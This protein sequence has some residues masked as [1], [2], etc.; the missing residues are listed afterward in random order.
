VPKALQEATASFSIKEWVDAV[1][2]AAN[3]EVVSESEE[4][5][6][7]VAKGDPSKELFPLKMRDAGQA[8][9]FA[10]IKS[11]GL[12]P[13]DDSDD[14]IPVS[15]RGARWRE[16]PPG[17]DSACVRAW[18][19]ELAFSCEFDNTCGCNVIWSAWLSSGCSVQLCLSYK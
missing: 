16:V 13:E 4:V 12:I 8:A 5:V 18:A 14:Y 15:G 11:K 2:K 19:R 17:T 1:A 3:A 6:K 9:G 7:M 10:Y